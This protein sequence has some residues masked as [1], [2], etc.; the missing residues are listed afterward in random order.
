MGFSHAKNCVYLLRND[1]VYRRN[2]ATCEEE[3]VFEN[4][5]YSGERFDETITFEY[6]EDT[7]YIFR[8]SYRNPDTSEDM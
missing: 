7:L 3:L 6:L 1:G 4:Y 5:G 8:E 2:L